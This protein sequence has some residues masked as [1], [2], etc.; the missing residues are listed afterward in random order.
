[1][2]FP[3]DTTIRSPR[4]VS[5]PGW[6]E[7]IVGLIAYVL[8]FGAVYLILKVIPDELSVLNGIIQLA[9]SGIMGLA[10]FAAAVAVKRRGLAAFGLRKASWKSLL[11]GAVLGV[12]CWI[13]GTI[14]SLIAYS[15]NGGLDNVQG[16]Y[17]AAAVGGV[18][19]VIGTVIT[20]AILT[21]IGE[22]FFFRG[23]LTSGLLRFGPWVGI[24]VSAAVF[25]LA[26]GI[27]PVLPVAFIVGI[28][29]GILF[30]RTGSVWPGVV[31]HAFNNAS[32]AFVP[33]A[34][35]ALVG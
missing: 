30:H 34:L 5:R 24:I 35:A 31:V 12:V 33:L 18:L 26:H 2:Q 8:A 3:I 23:V 6:A 15:V 32:A 16:D 19:A 14:A 1:M 7:M 27:N 25:A 4:R 21:P 29:N 28:I 10:A 20:G 22:E 9:L 11:L 13:L 17:Q